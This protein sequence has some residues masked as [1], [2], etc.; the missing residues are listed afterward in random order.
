MGKLTDCFVILHFVSVDFPSWKS[1]TFHQ[2]L[3]LGLAWLVWPDVRSPDR[4]CDTNTP[5]LCPWVQ[6]MA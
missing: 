2:G 1:K 4:M 3:A 6:L 5:N